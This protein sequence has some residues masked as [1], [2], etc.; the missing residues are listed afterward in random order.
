[1]RWLAALD[2]GRF[3]ADSEYRRITVPRL[4]GALAEIIVMPESSQWS[5]PPSLPDCA[6][7]ACILEATAR[8]PGNVH[9]QARFAD[10]TYADFVR[11]AE[12]AAPMV[13]QAREWGVGRAVHDAIAA[14][15]RVVSTNTNLGIVL[16][17]A[18]LCAVPSRQKLTA[19]IGD[20]LESLTIEDARWVYRAIQ[21][22]QPGGLG[23]APVGDIAVGP[24][25]TLLEMMRLAADRDGVA[26]QYAN[27]FAWVLSEGLSFLETVGRDFQEHWES[28][29]LTLHVRLLAAHPDT[30]IARKCGL[31]VAVEASERARECLAAAGAVD[32]ELAKR[33]D[34]SACRS[35]DAW[36]RA[37]GHRRNPGTTADLVAA[38]LFAALREGAIEPPPAFSAT[39]AMTAQC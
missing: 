19:G 22:A 35:L 3:N 13:A 26:A 20:V 16:L 25:G 12:V 33:I 39:P 14:T 36:L 37:D 18:P 34:V 6:R 8:K 15:R 30:L 1:M 4:A 17:L 38:S 23:D 7:W 27:R 11:S 21:R 32:V 31:R 10:L 2:V 24:T 9:P 5:C 28:A 29:I